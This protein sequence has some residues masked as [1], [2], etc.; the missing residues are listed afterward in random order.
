MKALTKSIALASV[1]AMGLGLSACDSKQENA[2]E[3]QA[4]A[5][6]DSSEAAADAIESQAANA[7]GAAEDAAE[8]KADAVRDTGDAKA[9][10][11]EDQADKLSAPKSN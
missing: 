2:A 1:V 7:T 5:V 3:S 9:D 10:K 6:R 4:D 11:L 8:A